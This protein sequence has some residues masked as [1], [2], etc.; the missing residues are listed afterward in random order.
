MVTGQ[1]GYVVDPVF[2]VGETIDGYTPPG[3]LD[4]IGAYQLDDNTVRVIVNH[5]IAN[6]RGYS[7]QVDGTN[8]SVTIPGGARLSYFDIDR[9]TLQIVDSGLAFDTIY[10]REGHVVNDPAT[11]LDFGSLNRFCSGQLIEAHQFGNGIG[12]QD[13]IYFAGEENSG[14]TEWALDTATG[15]LW[16]APAM[17]HAAWENVTELNTGRTDKVAFLIGDDRAGAP[18]LLY[19]G[20]KNPTGNFLGRNGL[21]QGKLYVW[22][23]DDPTS[24][25]DEIEANPSQFNGTGHSLAGQ[26]V[27]ID[28]YR[29]DLK[30]TREDL[31]GDGTIRATEL[32]YDEQGYATQTKQDALAR[33]VSNFQ[34]SRPE[35]VS[36][37]PADGTQVVLA[38][39]GRAELFGGVDTWGT[40]Y[41]V[42]VDFAQLAQGAITAQLKILYDGDDAGAGQFSN[43]DQGLRNPDNVNWSSDGFIYIQ[44]DRSTTPSTLFGG[45]SGEEA[46]IWQLDP[47]TGDLTRIAQ[48]DRSAI[49]TGQTDSQP[50]DIGNWE[51]SG[52]LDV[53]SL[54]EQAP[55]SLFLFDVQAHSLTGNA[56]TSQNLVEGGQLAF[57]VANQTLNGG[58]GADELTG[59]VGDDTLVG[60]NG[61]DTL[62]GNRGDDVL[63]GGNG[64]DVFVLAKGE[65]T[66]TITDFGTGPDVIGLAGGLTFGDLSFSGNNILVASTNEVLATLT[67]VDTTTLT[68]R[69]F[70]LI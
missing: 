18:L 70:V 64:K 30:N 24:S 23:A 12:L 37:N 65:G 58:N 20:D 15:D 6:G 19:V 61:K 40:T 41:L 35:D 55:G 11:Q 43:P 9:Q 5:E 48:I 17:G 29:P 44:E 49:P 68:A 16:A 3:I 63:T 50:T 60:G 21:S 59:F 13:R 52:I 67:G 31:N 53:S 33:A 69:D 14:G 28:Y 8:G 66:D 57:L 1:N 56:L 62:R 22:V 10:D 38:S 4:G 36:T 47:E 27:E 54:F 51:T 34:F 32:A 7:Y 26:F 42:D 2:T 46:S 25:T 45:T 39:T